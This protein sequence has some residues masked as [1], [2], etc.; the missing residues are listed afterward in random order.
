MPIEPRRMMMTGLLRGLA[1]RMVQSRWFLLLWNGGLIALL[2]LLS[3]L[4]FDTG[5]PLA[6]GLDLFII[7]AIFGSSL[8]LFFA[9]GLYR[10][11]ADYEKAMIRAD[12]ERQMEMAWADF[13]KSH[14][15]AGE[16]IQPTFKMMQ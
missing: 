10:G 1:D 4:N 11:L 14:P 5:R 15:E 9:P 16:R 8:Y 12:C 2:S 6:V 13:C 7:G 3:Y